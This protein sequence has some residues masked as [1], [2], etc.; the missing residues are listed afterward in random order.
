MLC[1]KSG[2]LRAVTVVGLLAALSQAHPA[3]TL[4]EINSLKGVKPIRVVVTKLRPDVAADGLSRD[5][6]MRIMSERL[7]QQR[8]PVNQN[9]TNDLYLIVT[10]SPQ[11]NGMYAVHLHL[12]GRQLVALFHEF[13]RDPESRDIAATWR[14]GWIGIVKPNEFK[15]VEIALVRM[16]DRFIADWKIGNRG[17]LRRK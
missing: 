5:R 2:W 4:S 3:G 13:L 10:S 17:R 15:T 1:G 7:K 8:L 16:V 11:K 6:L 14:T 12:E 9:A